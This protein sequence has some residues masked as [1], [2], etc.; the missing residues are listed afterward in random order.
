M[1]QINN[2]L[3]QFGETRAVDIDNYVINQGDMLGLVGNNGAGKTTLFRLILDLLQANNCYVTIDGID[4]S[5]RGLEEDN[6]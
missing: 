4:V 3:K 5:K 6:G 2:L 1:I